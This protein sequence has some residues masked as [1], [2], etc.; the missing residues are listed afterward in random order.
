MESRAGDGAQA[1]GRQQLGRSHGLPVGATRGRGV[2]GH[3]D[4]HRMA[5]DVGE[6]ALDHHEPAR[7]D[8]AVRASP[9][10]VSD[11]HGTGGRRPVRAV[12]EADGG[13]VVLVDQQH[14]VAIV[15]A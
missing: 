1:L 6:G 2:V 4:L 9:G 8:V 3:H 12:A 13:A 14:V 10:L 7:V 5:M 11:L 15:G